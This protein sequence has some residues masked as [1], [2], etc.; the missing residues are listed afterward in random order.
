MNAGQPTCGLRE[1][2]STRFRAAST[3][4]GLV[5]CKTALICVSWRRARFKSRRTRRARACRISEGRA[6]QTPKRAAEQMQSVA[7]VSR[8]S[9]KSR[10]AGSHQ[11]LVSKRDRGVPRSCGER[12]TLAR[13][14][15]EPYLKNAH[16]TASPRAAA[17]PARRPRRGVRRSG[18]R[19]TSARSARKAFESCAPLPLGDLTA[20]RRAASR[21]GAD[22]VGANCEA[23]LSRNRA[24]VRV[25]AICRR[26]TASSRRWV[27]STGRHH[28][29]DSHLPWHRH[30]QLGISSS[31]GSAGMRN[32][33]RRSHRRARGGEEPPYQGSG[34]LTAAQHQIPTSLLR[35]RADDGRTCPIQVILGGQVDRERGSYGVAA[36]RAEKRFRCGR[37]ADRRLRPRPRER[38]RFQGSRGWQGR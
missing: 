21:P 2:F 36:A 1:Q 15:L 24:C 33:S 10:T 23:P 31:R 25:D 32:G 20:V 13:R 28:D 7:R 29:L 37:R 5:R 8:G 4:C 26:C 3:R 14:A 34:G 6:S 19:P 30:L 18:S 12:K 9:A 35:K 38:E 16:T 22:Y 17:P 27:S 11:F